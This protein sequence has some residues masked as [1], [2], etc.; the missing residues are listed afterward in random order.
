MS[1]SLTRVLLW[2]YQS[3]DSVVSGVACSKEQRKR[4]KYFNGDT[5]CDCSQAPETTLH[6]V[7]YKLLA[8]ELD[9]V[10]VWLKHN[11]LSL[12]VTIINT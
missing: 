4:W 3:L 8:I 10:D 1:T 12:N 9:Q 7:Q 6:M 5:T 11:T 2:S